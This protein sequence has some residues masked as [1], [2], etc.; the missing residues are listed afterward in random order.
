MKKVSMFVLAVIISIAFVATVFAQAPT[1]TT[2]EKKETTTTT[3]T[4]T[5]EKKEITT[6]TKTTKSKG[7]RFYGKVISMDTEAKMMTVKGKRGDMTFDVSN[8]EMKSEVKAGDRVFV[9]YMKKEGKM[10]ASVVKRTEGKKMKT[11]TTTTT[12][13]EK[14]E[15]T[16]APVK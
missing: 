7:M 3:T 11:K 15:E 4:T 14:T 16:A 9:K 13:E 5:P 2:E 6:T 1:G 12:T 10:M 8:A